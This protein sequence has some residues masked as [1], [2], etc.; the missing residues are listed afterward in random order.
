MRLV[1]H[2]WL[3]I[4]LVLVIMLLFVI[5]QTLPKPDGV[6]FEGQ[7]AYAHVTAQCALGPRPAGSTAAQATAKYISD[8]LQRVGWQATYQDFTYQGVALCNVIARRGEGSGPAILLGA[9]YDTRQRAD[10]D[11]QNPN[12]PVPGANDG[13]SGVAVLLE[14]ARVLG[15][16]KRPVILAF[17]DAED[18]GDLNGWEWAVGASYLAANLKEPVANM[19]LLD[20]IGDADQQ[21]YWESN[22]DAALRLQLWT[23]AA[24][25]GY[26]QQFIAQTKYSL[27]DDHIPFLRRGI[28]SVDIIDFDYP[29]WHTAQDTPDKVSPASLERVGRVLERW[30][31]G[32]RD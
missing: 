20:M 29:Y 16:P 18:Q 10:R 5:A 31:I 8:E 13:A 24:G 15:E 19:V 26:G 7:R 12:A 4:G 14:L 6:A 25:L 27:I 23:L 22:S 17:F 21:I 30:L 3:L 2:R 9:H 11:R 28:P 32:T 1:R